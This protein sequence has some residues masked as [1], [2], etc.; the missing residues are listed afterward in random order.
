M[1]TTLILLFAIISTS[2]W[3]GWKLFIMLRLIRDIEKC[4]SWIK[5][6][7]KVL[8]ARVLDKDEASQARFSKFQRVYFYAQFHFEGRSFGTRNV[9]LYSSE[10]ASDRI[11]VSRLSNGED[12]ELFINPNRPHESILTSPSSHGYLLYWLQ[13][14]LGLGAS[15]FI[16]YL[17]VA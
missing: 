6:T 17:W 13:V 16:L 7:A 2:A 5:I 12:V 14:M 1:F 11:H 15:S 3:T 9:S 8:D 4:K 10:R